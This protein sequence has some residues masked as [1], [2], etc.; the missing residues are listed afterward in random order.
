M[1]KN[2]SDEKID[3]TLKTIHSKNKKGKKSKAQAILQQWEKKTK[4]EE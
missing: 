2:K 4:E 3:E 1:L